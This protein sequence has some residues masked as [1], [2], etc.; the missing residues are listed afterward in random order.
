MEFTSP[1]DF[2]KRQVLSVQEYSLLA[3]RSFTN[4]FTQPRYIRDTLQQM[5]F[6]G[7]GSLPIVV[8]TGFSI[9]AVL[10]LNSANALAR[11]GGLSFTGQ[12]VALSMVRELG[13]VVTGLM[14]AGRNSTGIASELGSMKVNE[15]IDAM[16]ALGT[17]P[18]KKLVTPRV[19]ATVIMNFFLTIIADLM[20]LA[21]GSVVARFLLGLDMNQYWTT[22]WQILA[23]GDVFMGLTKPLFFGFI[24]ATI[25][26]YYGLSAKGGTQG[27]GRAT[28]QAM[29]VASV[30]IVVVDFFLTR[31]IMVWLPS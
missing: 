12:L 28:T 11:Y 19:I 3:V 27:V 17:D 26:C 1:S 8:L 15:Q 4:L 14:G 9:G 23:F 21:G 16:R 30:L 20:G 24:I 6:I 10:A 29:V 7:V 31:I 13:P 2:A 22:A 25:G 5:D 18:T